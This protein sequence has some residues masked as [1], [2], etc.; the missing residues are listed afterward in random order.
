M[1]NDDEYKVGYGKPPKHSQFKKG[2]SGNPRGRRKAPRPLDFPAL[3]KKS[4]TKRVKVRVGGDVAY[5]SK[6]EAAAE[7][8]ANKLAS[9]DLRTIKMV[10]PILAK[11]D[12]LDGYER[13]A[14]GRSEAHR[15]LAE[16]LGLDWR[17]EDEAGA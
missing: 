9:G 3:L 10:L 2:Q 5:F 12:E 8:L 17:K 16:M 14:E 6:L 7:Q 4:M 13:D 15:K 1:S 11:L